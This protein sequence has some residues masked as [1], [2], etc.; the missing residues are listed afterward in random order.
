MELSKHFL[1]MINERKISDKWIKDCLEAT[2]LVE[3][4]YGVRHYIKLISEANNRW[5]RVIIN[6]ESSPNIAITCFFDR[7]LRRK[8]ENKS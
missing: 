1:E 2:D 3:N 4:E 7:R 8:H 5:L 6:I